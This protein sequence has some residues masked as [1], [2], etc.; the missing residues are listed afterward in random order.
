[1]LSKNSSNL[2][3]V[4]TTNN[5]IGASYNNIH[6]D[7]KRIQEYKSLNQFITY[8]NSN[9]KIGELTLNGEFSYTKASIND[10][11]Y[12]SSNIFEIDRIGTIGDSI[13]KD[14]KLEQ[15]RLGAGL[16]WQ[17]SSSS[18]IGINSNFIFNKQYSSTD[19][20]VTNTKVA[21]S[22]N[23][24]YIYQLNQYN[25]MGIGIETYYNKKD[26]MNDVLNK[27]SYHLFKFNGFGMYK[28]KLI[29]NSVINRYYQNLSYSPY[30]QYVFLGDISN[31]TELQILFS[32]DEISD[33]KLRDLDVL[34]NKRIE[35][36]F[37]NNS[38]YK[39][40]DLIYTICING[41][42]GNSEMLE[43]QY[44]DKSVNNQIV[45]EKLY[46]RKRLEVNNI[47]AGFTFKIE[48]D[49]SFEFSIKS[50]YNNREEKCYE[51]PDIFKYNLTYIDSEIDLIKQFNFS[52]NHL[53]IGLNLGYYKSLDSKLELNTQKILD[54]QLNVHPNLKESDANYFSLD[55]LS[56]SFMASYYLATI[57]SAFLLKINQLNNIENYSFNTKNTNIEFSINYYF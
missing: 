55:K 1:L 57:K 54:A 3:Y 13:N 30:I 52:K 6:K 28:H 39:N 47:L 32:E 24:S 16:A 12:N 29:Q 18:T 14:F 5:Y 41:E 15:Y 42:Y 11:M 26:F 2:I 4:D 21:I 36:K 35:Y 23:T 25:S 31:L 43:S 7:I 40:S 17:L 56:Q 46:D 49:N 44:I 38:I 50:S 51:I 53:K 22:L 8:V 20:R 10:I 19:P 45:Y 34:N 9:K 37:Q 33:S 48:K 27:T